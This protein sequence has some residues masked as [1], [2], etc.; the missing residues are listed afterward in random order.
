ML[1]GKYYEQYAMWDNKKETVGVKKSG[2][3]GEKYLQN[4]ITKTWGY[5]GW[6]YDS[7]LKNNTF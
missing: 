4:Y 7:L 3:I 5:I 6:F 2:L 1:P